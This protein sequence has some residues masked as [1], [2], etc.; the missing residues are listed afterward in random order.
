M[1]HIPNDVLRR[2]IILPKDKDTTGNKYPTPAD[3]LPRNPDTDSNL[4]R[5]ERE[6]Y[7][8]MKDLYKWQQ[9]TFPWREKVKENEGDEEGAN[10]K[11][12]KKKRRWQKSRYYLNARW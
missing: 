8:L 5:E 10:T 7:L 6:K 2:A 11:K 9:K 4:Q 1:I 12:T 3:L